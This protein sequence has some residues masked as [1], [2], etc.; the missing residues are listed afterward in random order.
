VPTETPTRFLPTTHTADFVSD[1][2]EARRAAH[3]AEL[4]CPILAS[5]ANQTSIAAGS[6]PLFCAT[7][8]G[9]AVGVMARPRG[10]LAVAQGRRLMAQRSVQHLAG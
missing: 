1:L 4:F 10:E 2:L 7:S 8:A 3:E 5:S 6:R 9:M